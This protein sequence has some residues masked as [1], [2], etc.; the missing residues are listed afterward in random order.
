MSVQQFCIGVIFLALIALSI[1]LYT[2]YRKQGWRT[3]GLFMLAG[4]LFAVGQLA[5]QVKG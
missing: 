4:W 5:S 1:V 3:T 2:A